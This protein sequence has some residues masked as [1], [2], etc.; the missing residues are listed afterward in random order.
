MTEKAVKPTNED[1][2]KMAKEGIRL[3]GESQ[4]KTP[5]SSQNIRME[6]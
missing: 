1:L 4:L 6:F 2:D 3:N 5:N